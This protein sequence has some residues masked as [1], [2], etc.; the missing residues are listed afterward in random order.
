MMYVNFVINDDKKLEMVSHSLKPTTTIAI[1]LEAK[2]EVSNDL[3]LHCELLIDE[4]T[5]EEDKKIIL[6]Q[7]Q[8]LVKRA[9]DII[10]TLDNDTLVS[11]LSKQK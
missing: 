11:Y 2:N 10:Y 1:M 9:I 4:S 3:D 5:S 7:Q 8:D 6:S